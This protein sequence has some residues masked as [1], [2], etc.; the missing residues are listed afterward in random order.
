MSRFG[1]IGKSRLFISA[2]AWFCDFSASV[3][4]TLPISFSI[5]VALTVIRLICVLKMELPICLELVGI[6][7]YDK[8]DVLVSSVG[9]TSE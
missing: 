9:K 2:G 8:D 6:W 5:S 4:L 1:A 3:R 7:P